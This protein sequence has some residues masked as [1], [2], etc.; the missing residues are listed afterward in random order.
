[1][2]NQ[3][4]LV[5][6]LVAPIETK[7]LEDGKKVANMTIAVPRSYKNAEGEYD[8]D[9]VDCTLWNGVAE[10]TSEYCKK[11]DLLGVKGRVQTDL[12]EVDGEKKKR[13]YIVADKIT[14]LSTKSKY[15]IEEEPSKEDDLEEEPSK[16][17]DLEV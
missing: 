2:L 12:Y 8:T 17:D 16:E 5:G 7:E 15:D 9:F 6:R 3:T 13:T 1:M 4:V 14:F 11:G 10:T